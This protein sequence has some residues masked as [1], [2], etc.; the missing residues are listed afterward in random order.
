MTLDP[1]TVATLR[2]YRAHAARRYPALP[3][4]LTLA[5]DMSRGG[6]AFSGWTGDSWHLVQRLRG[7]KLSTLD[8]QIDT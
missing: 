4:T 5:A 1:D 2:D 3:W 8:R 7:V 6:P